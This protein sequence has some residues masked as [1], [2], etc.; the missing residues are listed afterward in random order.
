MT[1][2][3]LALLLSVDDLQPAAAGYVNFELTAHNRNVN[4]SYRRINLIADAKV[5]VALSEGL[6]IQG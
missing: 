5:K 1:D 2:N 6:E 3:K 4:A